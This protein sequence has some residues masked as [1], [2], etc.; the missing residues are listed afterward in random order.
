MQQK[1][2]KILIAN[3]IILSLGL[4][5][6]AYYGIF[7]KKA[8]RTYTDEFNI[9]KEKYDVKNIEIYNRADNIDVNFIFLPENSSTLLEA[10]LNATVI[11]SYLHSPLKISISERKSG[12]TLK[13]TVRSIYS[14]DDF[15]STAYGW[16]YTIWISSDYENYVFDS[17]TKDGN[18]YLEAKGNFV[19]DRF[20]VSTGD[21]EFRGYLNQTSIKSDVQLF[22]K[23]GNIFLYVDWLNINGD[24]FFNSE[25][26]N[27]FLDFW[28]VVFPKPA[29]V[30]LTSDMG[31]IMFYWAQHVKRNNSVQVNIESNFKSEMKFWCRNEFIRT[32]V[33]LTGDEINFLSEYNGI[34]NQ[35]GN[36]SYQNTNFEDETADYFLFDISG[37]DEVTVYVVNCFKPVRFHKRGFDGSI[38]RSTT[39]SG[40]FEL[41]NLDFSVNEIIF[42][43]TT[44]IHFEIPSNLNVTYGLLDEHS[45]KL[46]E[47]KW[48]LTY[49]Y[50]ANHGY[51]S[52]LPSFN[53]TVENS[54]LYLDLNL[55]FDEKLIYPAFTA[56]GLIFNVHPNI[57]FTKIV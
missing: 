43:D 41:D 13:I 57:T 16:N 26:G 52:L 8:K 50:A 17:D 39:I 11:E 19:F 9:D 56:G 42:Q 12:D 34:F 45:E 29:S 14:K 24:V 44:P 37:M 47:A 7:D 38:A 51:G 27:L 30:N 48:N 2:K 25:S 18:V 10:Y 55:E 35:I 28:E 36:N 23:T 22:S 5:S 31:S 4:I 53:Y 20:E 3:T 40:S 33:R 1:T 21:G 49:L 15:F 32:E 46:V 6:T 54:I